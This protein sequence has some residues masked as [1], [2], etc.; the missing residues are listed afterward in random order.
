MNDRAFTPGAASS[1]Q[2]L[3]PKGPR[4]WYAYSATFLSL[5]FATQA[6]QNIAIE[7]DSDFWLTAISYQAFVDDSDVLTVNTNVVPP[8]T[9]QL[10]DSGSSRN[11]FA[12]PVS[13]N[14]LCGDGREPHRLIHP[15]LF[16]RTSNIQVAVVNFGSASDASLDYLQIVFEGFKVYGING[17]NY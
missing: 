13:I 16:R 1:Q 14:T 3:I 9:L 15:R 8:V 5:T 12:A 10:T 17:P 2:G 4:D 7:A 6:T 11:L